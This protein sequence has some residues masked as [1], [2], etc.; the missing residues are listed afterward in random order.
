VDGLNH[1]NVEDVRAFVERRV[2]DDYWNEDL[3]CAITSLKI[4]SERFETPVHSQVLDAALGMHGAG[5]YGAQCGLVE[6]ALMYLGLY[7]R[8]NGLRDEEVVAACQAYARAFEGRFGSLLCRELRPDGFRPD[9]PPHLCEDLSCQV[10]AFDIGYISDLAHR[11]G[12]T[13]PGQAP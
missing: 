2:H 4:L 12:L 11:H 3:N 6:G 8:A 1:Q 13:V 5:R 10:I 7:G 9:D